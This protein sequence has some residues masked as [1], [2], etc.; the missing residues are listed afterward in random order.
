MNAAW[1]PWTWVPSL[2]LAESIPYAIAMTVSV[3]LYKDIGA[4]QHADRFLHRLALS[5]L[6]HQAAMESFR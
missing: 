4:F 2:Y 5:S 3:V 1:N 6:G